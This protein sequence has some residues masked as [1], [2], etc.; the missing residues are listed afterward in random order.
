[1][2]ESTSYFGGKSGSGTYQTI[3]NQI[4]PQRVY[5]ELFG[6]MLGIYRHKRPAKSS[7]I[8]EKDKSLFEVYDNKF[9]IVEH[10]LNA[11]LALALPKNS[12]VRSYNG[13]AL[14]VFN[15]H[16]GLSMLERED[17]FIYADPPYPHESR[18]SNSRYKHDMTDEEHT[19]LLTT[20]IS[21]HDTK[22]ALSTYPND[23]YYEFFYGRNEWRFIEF[24]SQ[25][26]G[27]KAIEQLWMNYPEPTELH[28]YRYLGE[29][30]RERERITRKL[31]RWEAKFRDL[32]PLEQMAML[33]RLN[34][35]LDHT[36]IK[37]D[38]IS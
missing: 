21:F 5:V 15:Y 16:S 32:A 20:L 18:S 11:T 25:T 1:M 3:I 27:G 19:D 2:I 30:Y 38:M 22:V 10:N 26:R 33:Q 9:G 31:K 6:G 8:F 36:G 37:S 29:D 14:E 23:L 13:C 34:G 7:I 35:T 28:D 4:P 17:V 12:G 24:E